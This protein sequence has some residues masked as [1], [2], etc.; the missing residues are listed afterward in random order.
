MRLLVILLEY[1]FF[2]SSTLNM[3]ILGNLERLLFDKWS[4]FGTH[5]AIVKF[6]FDWEELLLA[7]Q[8]LIIKISQRLNINF[9]C[10]NISLTSFIGAALFR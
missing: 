10:T 6:V 5:N 3:C 9:D 1:L 8:K 7:I 2:I 4:K